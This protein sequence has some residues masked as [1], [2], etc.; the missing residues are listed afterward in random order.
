MDGVT[1]LVKFTE[2]SKKFGGN[3]FVTDKFPLMGTSV[4]VIM[5]YAEIAQVGALDMGVGVIAAALHVLPDA[6]GDGLS[7]EPL[8]KGLALQAESAAKPDYDTKNSIA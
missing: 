3:A 1:G 4:V 5:A 6:V 7:R 8:R 2:N